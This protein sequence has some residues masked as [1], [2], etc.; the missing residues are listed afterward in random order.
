MLLQYLQE[1]AVRKGT[2]EE[3]DLTDGQ[4]SSKTESTQQYYNKCFTLDL[5]DSSDNIAEVRESFWRFIILFAPLI[6]PF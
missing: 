4:T 5:S 2:T 3:D 1:T 6:F